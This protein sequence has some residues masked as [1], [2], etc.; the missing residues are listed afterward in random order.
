[1][2]DS[3]DPPHQLPQT[4]LPPCALTDPA[5]DELALFAEWSDEERDCV[6][7]GPHHEEQD[8]ENCDDVRVQDVQVPDDSQDQD[9]QVHLLRFS[10][11]N[12]PDILRLCILDTRVNSK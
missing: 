12:A 2:E 4:V 1:M 3:T 10:G 8:E 5:H 6:G 9:A 11:A 7:D